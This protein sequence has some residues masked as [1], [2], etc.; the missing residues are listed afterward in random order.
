MGSFFSTAGLLPHG[1][2]IL[3]RPD[4]LALHVVS[5][6]LIA[7][8]YF[9]IPIAILTFIRQ[10]PDL[11]A[12][13]KWIA[14]LFSA[15][16]LGCGLTHVMGVVVLWYPAYG[17]EGLIKA[18]TALASIVTAAV[19]WPMLPRL[20]QIPSPTRLAEANQ[21]LEREA[22][23]RHEALQELEAAR[24]GLEA[25]VG[26]RTEQSESLARQLSAILDTVPDAMIVIDESGSIQSASA[27]A[28]R[29]FG[30]ASDEMVGRNVKMLMPEPYRSEHDGYLTHYL[31]TGERR[32]IG[33][34]RVVMGQRRD[35]GTFP[36]ELSVGEFKL[37]DTRQFTGFVRDLTERQEREQRMQELQAELLHV[38]RLNEIGQMASAF[39]HELNQPLSAASNYLSGVRRLVEAGATDRVVQGCQRAAEQI[40]RAGDVIRRLRDFVAKRETHRSAENLIQVLEEGSALA[41]VGT[42]SDGVKT[43]MRLSPGAPLAVMDKIEIQQVLVNLIRNAVEAMSTSSRRELLIS[44]A[45]AGAEEVEIAIS[46]TGPGLADSIRERLFQPFATTKAAGMG[47]GLSLCRTII[48]AHGGRI[49]AEDNPAG[50]TI[51]RFTLP[52]A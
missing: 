47:V 19:L 14:G 6:L 43:E 26:R 9:S 40:A 35:G 20:L 1:F 28:E 34:G 38:A 48:E 5:D 49:W 3:W 21:R 2:C 46:D 23:A 52:T 41:L 17:L 42:R 27:T 44:S 51:F 16:I 31:Q 37:N 22:A 4:I 12:E 36:M 50:G 15:F 33:L 30:Y 10:R 25:E 39:A 13:H 11:L 8:A 7:A 32:I 18:F 24:A 29:L 45:P